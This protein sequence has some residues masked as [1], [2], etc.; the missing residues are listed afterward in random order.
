MRVLLINQF[1]RS[2]WAPSGQLLSDLACHLASLGHDVAVMCGDADV[3]E[4]STDCDSS[5]ISI[6][7]IPSI[8]FSRGRY[9]RMLS[10]LSFYAGTL[11]SAL[12]IQRPDV[13]LTLTTPPLLSLVGTFAK[14]LRSIRHVSW[15]M[16]VYPNI[17][18]ELGVLAKGAWLT[19]FTK[20]LAAWSRGNADRVIAIGEDMRDVLLASGAGAKKVVVVENWADSNRIR[21]APFPD[22]PLQLLYAGNIG[23]AHDVETLKAAILACNVP[24]L[25]AKFHFTFAGGGWHRPALERFAR[26]HKLSNISLLGAFRSTNE[27]LAGCHV[28]LVTQHPNV[29]GSA[30]PSKLYP[31]LAA[32]RPVIY[33]GPEETTPARILKRFDC[34][35][36]VP[37][38]DARKMIDLLKGL[39]QHRELILEAG[40]RARQA[41]LEHYDR[42]LALQKL[43]A[44]ITG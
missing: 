13:V 7:R 5:K 2:P 40:Q 14:K 10:Y 28:G 29:A 23:L 27:I 8:P 32:G 12:T 43:T 33:V 41:L 19:R 44:V 21:P 1:F 42:P 38:G 30:V 6:R 16:D 18:V 37:P 39:D 15:E 3:R 25:A 26:D 9:K 17:A 36:H 20:R 31:L 24:E 34:G 22:G 11:W 35:W 4:H